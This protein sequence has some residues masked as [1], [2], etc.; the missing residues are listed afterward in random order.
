M[1][2]AGAQNLVNHIESLDRLPAVPVIAMREVHVWIP[3]G[4]QILAGINWT[5]QPGEHWAL[6]GPNGS[7]KTTLLSLAGAQRHPSSGSV[8]VLG[9]TLG[10]TSMGDLRER[11]GAIDPNQ[12]ILDWLSIEEVVLTGLTGT[13]WPQPGRATDADRFRALEL[14][15][16]VGCLTLRQR[17]I[18]TCSQGERQRVRIA[19]AL[20]ADPPLLLLDEPA[21]GLDLPAREALLAAM[22]SLAE[23]HSRLASVFVSHHLEELPVSTTH[24]ALLREGRFVTAGP[25]R[26]TLTSENVSHCFGFPIDVG[27][28]GNRWT[29][30]A[31]A[32]WQT[33]GERDGRA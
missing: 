18:T 24:A 2:S 33:R 8:T 28:H 11:I 5:V 3:D 12:K 20:M 10:R 22:S 17:E 26:E 29:A 23:S 1:T 7:G 16:L 13:V 9:E 32:S 27:E 6:L 19:R 14:L 25:V 30:R 15:D 21:T 4:M 31:S